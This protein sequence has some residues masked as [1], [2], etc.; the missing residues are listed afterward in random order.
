MGTLHGE[1]QFGRKDFTKGLFL[2]ALQIELLFP[3]CFYLEIKN[4]NIYILLKYVGLKCTDCG[5]TDCT[6]TWTTIQFSGWLNTS[7]QQ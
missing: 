6:Q 4:A 1:W 2:F 7:I 3:T 5:Y